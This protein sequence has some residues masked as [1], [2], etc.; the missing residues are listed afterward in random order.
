[1]TPEATTVDLHRAIEAGDH[2]GVLV[3]VKS[4]AD[5][6]SATP[7]GLDAIHALWHKTTVLTQ[8]KAHVFRA[9]VQAGATPYLDPSIDV[10]FPD[11]REHFLVE[12][13]AVL[14][15]FDAP[16]SFKDQALRWFVSTDHVAAWWNPP[17][18]GRTAWSRFGDQHPVDRLRSLA[19]ESKSFPLFEVW[20]AIAQLPAQIA[21]QR[22]SERTPMGPS[23]LSPKSRL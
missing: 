21:Q 9:L 16:S 6:V 5:V 2:A 13:A 18:H 12:W 7:S 4:G 20:Q 23:T 8:K 3:A 10:G 11:A 17:P 1:M 19:V 22:L 14:Q 15:T